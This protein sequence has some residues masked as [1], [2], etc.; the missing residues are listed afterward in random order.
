MITLYS[1]IQSDANVVLESFNKAYRDVDGILDQKY[2]MQIFWDLYYE[3]FNFNSYRG[4]YIL[5]EI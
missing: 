2:E 3:D 4:K 1:V 5:K